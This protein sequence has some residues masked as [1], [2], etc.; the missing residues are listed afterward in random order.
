MIESEEIHKFLKENPKYFRHCDPEHPRSSWH[1]IVKDGEDIGWIWHKNLLGGWNIQ[2]V[3]DPQL[4][5]METIEDIKKILKH[6]HYNQSTAR[7]WRYHLLQ[8][9]RATLNFFRPQ[10]N[11]MAR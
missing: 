6:E 4:H 9:Y 1:V 3:Y 5:N 8:C 7:T 10:R 2:F 11:N